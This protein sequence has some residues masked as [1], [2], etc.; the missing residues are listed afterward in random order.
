MPT[1]PPLRDT[2]KGRELEASVPSEG[3]VLVWRLVPHCKE[4]E[5]KKSIVQLDV[6]RKAQVQNF[7]TRHQKQGM[8][9]S[10]GDVGSSISDSWPQNI[11]GKHMQEK[12]GN[13][14]SDTECVSRESQ[15]QLE[16]GGAREGEKGKNVEKPLCKTGSFQV[17]LIT[18]QHCLKSF[19]SFPFLLPTTLNSFHLGSQENLMTCLRAIHLSPFQY[20]FY[21]VARSIFL[22]GKSDHVILPAQ[23]PSLVSTVYL[24]VSTVYPK[25][26][27]VFEAFHHLALIERYQSLLPFVFLHA[28]LLAFLFPLFMFSRHN[29]LLEPIIL[30]YVQVHC[31]EFISPSLL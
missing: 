30:L 17:P 25:L 8:G 19:P 24:T 29:L 11:S 27:T 23:K 1:A 14:Y 5:D 7:R 2:E 10:S 12:A 6:S 21:T 9:N 4:R 13:Y 26:S 31:F 15:V 20:T 16:R 18:Y 28:R 22:K 3:K